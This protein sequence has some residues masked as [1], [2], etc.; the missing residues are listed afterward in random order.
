MT[1]YLCRWDD[2]SKYMNRIVDPTMEDIAAHVEQLDI[3]HSNVAV[4]YKDSGQVTVTCTERPDRV[5]VAFLGV[6]APISAG[7][8]L[9]PNYLDSDEIIS[10]PDDED[11]PLRETVDKDYALDVIEYYMVHDVFPDV[12]VWDGNNMDPFMANAT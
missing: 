5:S 3:V 12:T 9:D 6:D 11:L 4:F 2:A 1:T 10:A 7:R 8:L